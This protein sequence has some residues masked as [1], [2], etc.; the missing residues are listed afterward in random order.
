MLDLGIQL[1]FTFH[2]I[3]ESSSVLTVEESPVAS[4]CTNCRFSMTWMTEEL[5]QSKETSIF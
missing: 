5:Q 3:Q 4:S 1:D 2:L